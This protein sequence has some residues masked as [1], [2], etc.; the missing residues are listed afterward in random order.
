MIHLTL[1]LGAKQNQ[2][3]RCRMTKVL[4]V[5]DI[6]KSMNYLIFGGEGSFLK[7]LKSGSSC[8]KKNDITF[9]KK[10]RFNNPTGKL[11]FQ[12]ALFLFLVHIIS[13]LIK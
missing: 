10:F 2:S 13:L 1:T 3:A 6:V 5:W 9:K 12:M 11:L 8:R 4:D 7:F